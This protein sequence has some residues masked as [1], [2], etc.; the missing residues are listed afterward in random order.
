MARAREGGG[1]GHRTGRW[2]ERLRGGGRPKRGGSGGRE[3]L[4]LRAFNGACS[5]ESDS[6]M[7][8]K[9]QFIVRGFDVWRYPQALDQDWQIMFIFKI[10][11]SYSL[12]GLANHSFSRLANHI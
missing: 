3:T 10:G 9:K 6:K 5:W 8:C 7:G 11:K 4:E 2:W 12:S 1:D